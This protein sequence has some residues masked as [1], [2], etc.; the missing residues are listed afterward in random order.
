MLLAVGSSLVAAEPAHAAPTAISNL[1]L[2]HTGQT[3]GQFQA[4]LAAV[5]GGNFNQ[6]VTADKIWWIARPV[7]SASLSSSDTSDVV[8]RNSPATGE[9]AGNTSASTA[10]GGSLITGQLINI[11]GLT[12]GTA[13]KFYFVLRSTQADNTTK[14]YSTVAM[15]LFTTDAASQQAGTP[16]TAPGVPTISNGVITRGTSGVWAGASQN[17][18]GFWLLCS[19]SHTASSAGVNASDCGPISATALSNQTATWV[20][21]S[22]LTITPT[23]NKWTSCGGQGGGCTTSVV[24]TAGMFLAWYEYDGSNNMRSATAAID[25]VQSA[26]VVAPVLSAE[27]AKNVI[28]PLPVV[29][30]QVVAAIPSFNK[31]LLAGGGKIDTTAGDFTG[32]VS[33][34]IGGKAVEFKAPTSGGISVTVPAGQA[35]TTADLVL[36]FKTG[37]IIFQDAI[38]YVAP[39]VVANVPARPISVSSSSKSFSEEAKSEITQ[40]AFANVRNT[41]VA[42]VGYAAA[43]SA[44]SQAAA[45]EVATKACAI[46]N[47]SN[48]DLTISEVTVV[49]DA[50]KA[51]SQGVGIKVYKADN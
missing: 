11:S 45:M 35:G 42:C 36:T 12:A 29:V 4:D 41:A 10:P 27:Q 18:G 3:S 2:L 37:P 21:T 17:L 5:T 51:R 20:T 28:K 22:P 14:A 30:Q 1:V 46:A 32:L 47:K 16:L 26:A 24:N 48:S 43:S 9:V 31:P 25:G 38:K 6:G 7:S 39:V 15:A 33:A 50:Q 8:D 13:Y 34:S 23:F 49:V 19:S 44:S 40:A